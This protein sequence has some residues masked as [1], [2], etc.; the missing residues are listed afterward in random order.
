MSAGEPHAV[1]TA[2]L[3]VT[4][5]SG[6]GSAPAVLLFVLVMPIAMVQLRRLRRQA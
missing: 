3:Y 2:V 6:R 5:D 4:Y 1:G